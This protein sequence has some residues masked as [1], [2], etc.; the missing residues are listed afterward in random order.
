MN[1]DILTVLKEQATPLNPMNPDMCITA[2]K[3]MGSYSPIPTTMRG[4]LR[5]LHKQKKLTIMMIRNN[6]YCLMP[7][8]GSIRA[9]KMWVVWTDHFK[10]YDPIEVMNHPN[11]TQHPAIKGEP[12]EKVEQEAPVEAAQPEDH[13]IDLLETYFD[14]IA[15]AEAV[16]ATAGRM[17]RES[18]TKINRIITRCY[19]KQNPDGVKLDRVTRKLI[20]LGAEE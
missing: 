2:L 3:K 13:T 15:A 5:D 1:R 10:G 20:F 16:I 12:E 4:W 7:Q 8:D 19:P 11:I 6:S 9:T 14:E 17:L 18:Q